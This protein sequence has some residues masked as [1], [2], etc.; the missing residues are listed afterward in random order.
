VEDD[1][2]ATPQENHFGHGA[3]S[4]TG[5]AEMGEAKKDDGPYGPWMVLSRRINGR[6]GTNL[7]G[8]TEGSTK[9][10]RNAAPQPPPN[11]PE[12]RNTATSRAAHA[13]SM[14]RN[15]YVPSS[16]DHHKRAGPSWTP[17]FAGLGS[18][19]MK[20]KSVLGPV[21]CMPLET[22]GV[23]HGEDS[24][25]IS[26]SSS[27]AQIHRKYPTSV[28]GKKVIARGLS[29]SSPNTD[30]DFARKLLSAKPTPLPLLHTSAL[31]HGTAGPFDQSF[32]FTVAASVGRVQQKD[33]R[34][35]SLSSVDVDHQGGRSETRSLGDQ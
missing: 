26:M 25:P 23:N 15:V 4:S 32:K 1:R 17:S 30:R 20:E 14:S 2:S 3:Q 16:G 21:D 33:G 6:K 27:Q 31:Y 7:V 5:M 13:P 18:M 28:K 29:Q 24:G 11:F 34:E 9:S 8:S 22:E 19:S 35:P 12:W 10:A